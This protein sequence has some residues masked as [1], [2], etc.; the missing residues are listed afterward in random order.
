MKKIVFFII[1]ILGVIDILNAQ[2]F[3]HEMKIENITKDGLYRIPLNPDF[4]QFMASDFHDLRILDSSEKEVPY[5]LL[6]EPLLKSKSDFVPYEISSQTHHGTYSE[7]VILN[8]QKNK[9][10]N[11]AFN[12]N[13]SDA[14]KYCT[15][16][17]SDDGEQWFTISELQELTLLYNDVYT[18]QYKCIYFPLNN[19]AYFRLLVD[20]WNSEPLKIN[21]AGYFKNSVIA[22]KLN[23][24]AFTQVI[25]ED[26]KNKKT[27]IALS[28][29]NNQLI[30]RLDFKIKEPRLF[31]RHAIVYVNRE[32]KIKD[33]TEKYQEVLY[34][35]EMKSDEALYFDVPMLN[36]KHLVIEIDN[37]D[38]PPLQIESI[39]CKQL[40]TYLVA[41]F[42]ATNHYYL[43]CGN[44][45][46]K[47][48]EYDLI[49]FLSQIPQLLPEVK[50]GQIS[51]IKEK[52][53][54]TVVKEK[55]FYETSQFLWI[56]LGF[57]VVII[58]F[59]SKSL[60]K[61]MS[62]NKQ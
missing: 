59:F 11:I 54:A 57:V 47:S 39:H 62:Q 21:S 52:P 4:Q 56:C 41:D 36:E 35:F 45:L 28:F 8:P 25:K 40:A 34:E 58:F 23:D 55:A 16:E 13:N 15:I 30:D 26:E 10:S 24:V 22:G 51:E 46:L 31:K 5:V 29:K 43:K 20:D 49:N 17:G 3:S 1:T 6:R 18:N 19:Y 48:P 33:K 7:I 53:V 12:I 37:K 42:K 44:E 50:L 61:D 60:L 14:F 2:N 27:I 32:R 9:I 38:N